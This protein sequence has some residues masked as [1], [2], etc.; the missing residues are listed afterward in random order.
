MMVDTFWTATNKMYK[1]LWHLFASNMTFYK[2]QNTII[3]FK[4]LTYFLMY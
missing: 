2:N 3:K 1:Y 4:Q